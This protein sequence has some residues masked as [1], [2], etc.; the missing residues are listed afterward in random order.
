[1]RRFDLD[2]DGNKYYEEM[3]ERDHGDYVLFDEAQE[4]IEQLKERITGLRNLL[5]IATKVNE[6]SEAD[7]ELRKKYGIDDNKQ[8][9]R[10]WTEDEID[11]VLN[12]LKENDNES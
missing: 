11:L 6:V 9:S 12:K 2:T 1:M 5:A 10:A 4:E 7:K 3:I 8:I